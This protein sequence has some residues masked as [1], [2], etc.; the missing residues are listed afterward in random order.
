MKAIKIQSPGHAAEVEVPTPRLRPGHALVKTI[1]VALNP[2]DWK[3]IHFIPSEGCTGG[4]DYAGIVEDPNGIPGLA[5][6]DRIAGFVH[7][8]NASEHEDGAFA[9]YLTA[10]E[11]LFMK[12]PAYMSFEEAATTGAG[13]TTIGQAMYYSFGLPLPT[14]PSAE[15]FP[16]LIYGGSTATGALAIQFA[17]LSGLEVITTCSPR[18]FD[19]VKA[20]GASAVFD[21]NSPTCGADIRKHTKNALFYALDCISEGES[22]NICAEAL[23]TESSVKKPQYGILLPVLE[24][25]R[26]DVDKKFTLGYTATGEAFEKFGRHYPADEKDWQFAR[27]FWRLSQKLFE[28]GKLKAHA[29]D[30]RKQPLK[31]ILEGVQELK[32]GKVSGRKIVYRIADP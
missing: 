17:K 14:N 10:R 11:G 21:Y 31:N 8:G 27:L 18:N 30:I 1:A 20:L 15:S 7:G 13:V 25:S 12:I 23:S 3:H 26:T 28:D 9:E 5:V 29:Q 4:V 22:P 6:G 16:I 2:S 19:M 24:F 32:D